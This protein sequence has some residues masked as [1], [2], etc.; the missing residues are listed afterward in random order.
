V[1]RDPFD[2]LVRPSPREGPRVHAHPA[3][4]AEDLLLSQCHTGKSR[5]GGPG[6]QHRNKVETMVT[7]TH[8]PTG[9]AAHAGERRSA[10]ENRRVAFFRL[11]LSLAVEVREPVPIGDARSDLWIS[12]TAGSRISC[13]PGHADF[14]SLLAEALDMI[15]ACRYDAKK[16]ALRLSVTPS[17]LIKFVAEHP[18]ALA[19]WNRRRAEIGAH[20]LRV[21]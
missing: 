17:Q 6:G 13:N 7:I 16:A 14:P 18:H 15:H 5:S 4:I 12:R 8:E 1:T 9:V 19:L 20:P 2:D 3:S 21:D 11:R 10:E